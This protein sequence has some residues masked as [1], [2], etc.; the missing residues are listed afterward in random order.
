MIM[1]TSINEFKK[2]NEKSIY[3]KIGTIKKNITIELDLKHTMHS[4]TRRG[5]GS[6]FITNEDIKNA[7]DDATDQMIDL[8][9][10]NKLNIGDSI[11]ITKKS[12]DLN[13]VGALS[14]KQG[15]DIINF[16]VI[17]CMIIDNFLNKNN[18]L[19]IYI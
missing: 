6:I 9:I 10:A 2:Y 17:T 7:V 13:I 15:S 19:Q 16:T 4:L 11:L 3:N 8:I 5:R 1:I 12:N 18:T 14:L